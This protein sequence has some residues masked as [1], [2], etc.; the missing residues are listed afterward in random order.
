[1]QYRI[2]EVQKILGISA[3]TLRFFESKNIIK[4]TRNEHNRYRYYT[5]EDINKIFVYKMYRSMHFTMEE[6]IDLV[7]GNSIDHLHQILER[8][9][10]LLE[11]RKNV[12]ED[13]ISN[14]TYSCNIIK[15]FHEDNQPFELGMTDNMYFFE[16]QIEDRFVINEE[17]SQMIQRCFKQLHNCVPAFRCK[18]GKEGS[19]QYGYGMTT[20]EIDEKL[21]KLGTYLGKQRCFHGLVKVKDRS[22]L[23]HLVFQQVKLA[24][25]RYQMKCNSI[26]YGRMHHEEKERDNV[27]WFYEI[28]AM[29]DHELE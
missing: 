20:N 4:S 10:E 9:K 11:N 1:M 21:D 29:I 26:I 15:K 27:T 16:N 6:A 3:E 18:Y 12:I 25:E 22:E 5:N 2:G 13:I 19:I 23:Y 17:K 8:Q 24:E 7:S 28:W 14:L